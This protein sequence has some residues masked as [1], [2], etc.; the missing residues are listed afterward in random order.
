MLCTTAAIK[1]FSTEH[2]GLK[3]SSVNDW[4]VAVIKETKES[5]KCGKDAEPEKALVG[6]KRGKPG[7]LCDSISKEL[8]EYI[9]ALRDNG[10]VVNTAVLI[11]AATGILQER[12]P[13]SLACNGGH[14]I[15]QKSWAKYFLGKMQFVKRK[16]MTK[17]KVTVNHFEE[18]KQGYLMDIK[19]VVT[20]EDVPVDLVIN[21]D[22]TG[23]NY[24]PGITVDNGK[25][26]FQEGGSGR[27]E[28]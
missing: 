4:K 17:A 23:L 24:V 5:H 19:A 25:R 20:M 9:I 1:H 18:V 11:A 27:I 14:I 3:W 7:L 10:G 28:R 15:L 8:K 16:A 2:P 13:Q 21:W 12:N 6:K 22:Q 26:R